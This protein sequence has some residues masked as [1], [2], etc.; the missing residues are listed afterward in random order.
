M[1]NKKYKIVFRYDNKAEWVMRIVYAL[2]EE[3]AKGY[4]K[5]ETDISQNNIEFKSIT[6]I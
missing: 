3:Q 2:N 6:K 4:L 1:T 5:F